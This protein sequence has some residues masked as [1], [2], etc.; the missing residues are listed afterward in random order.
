MARSAVTSMPYRFVNPRS[1]DGHRPD[2]DRPVVRHELDEA[3]ARHHALEA[4]E[5]L[6]GEAPADGDAQRPQ[7]A[8]AGGVGIDEVAVAVDPHDRVGVVVGKAVDGAEL[9]AGQAH[10]VR[11]RRGTIGPVASSHAADRRP[12]VNAGGG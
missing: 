11:V 12:G 5:C 9:L 8:G 6:G 4:F 7:D 1:S 10:G 2:R 3:A